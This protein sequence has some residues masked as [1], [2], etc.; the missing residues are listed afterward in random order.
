V[1]RPPPSAPA[2]SLCCFA[3]AACCS[4]FHPHVL[5]L[6]PS[7]AALFSLII[8]WVWSDRQAAAKH[9]RDAAALAASIEAEKSKA[10][11]IAG[12]APPGK[13]SSLGIAVHSDYSS[14]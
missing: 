11:K 2:L 6:L 8:Y 3:A 14:M 9:K 7:R 13:I 10:A 12:L 5:P 4:C 1:R